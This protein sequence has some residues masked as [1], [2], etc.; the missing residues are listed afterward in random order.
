MRMMGLM[1]IFSLMVTCSLQSNPRDLGQ[2]KAKASCANTL[3]PGPATDTLSALVAE[4]ENGKMT[5]AC[6]AYVHLST[7]I[8]L[9]IW[10]SKAITKSYYFQVSVGSLVQNL[11]P[12]W[13]VKFP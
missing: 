7:P 11:G 9:I 5:R 3:E 12:T 6:E 10:E 4:R 8:K 2:G 13:G 1:W